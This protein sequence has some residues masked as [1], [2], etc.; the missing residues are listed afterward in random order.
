MKVGDLVKYIDGQ[1]ELELENVNKSEPNVFG[2]IMDTEE[3]SLYSRNIY[4]V[5]IFE[6]QRVYWLYEQQLQAISKV[7]E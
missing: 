3:D 6:T 4:K 2:M 5:F 7:I 1:L